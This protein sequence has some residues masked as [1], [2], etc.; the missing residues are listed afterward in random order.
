MGMILLFDEADAMFGQRTERV[1]DATDRF[2]NA[3]TNYLLQRLEAFDCIAV[4]T[5]NSKSRL[6]SAFTS[7]LALATTESALAST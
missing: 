4:L 5:T 6:D 7:Q 2:A 1:R 3:Q